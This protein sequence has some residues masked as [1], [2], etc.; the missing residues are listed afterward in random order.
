M[1]RLNFPE[2]SFRTRT[3][4]D[5]TEIYDPVRRKYVVLTPEEWVRQN[6]I[7]Y[8]IE[9]KRMPLSLMAIE[10]GFR[11]IKLPKRPD[12]VIFSP[13]GAPLLIVE[14]KAPGIA[15]S[16]D[17]FD[18]IVRYNMI[19]NALFLLVTN[20]MNHFI[21]EIDYRKTSYRFLKEIPSYTDIISQHIDKNK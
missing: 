21:C 5:K 16:Q 1:I 18:Q 4:K 8:L 15:V 9:E 11:L 6:T 3:T 14:C 10:A 20:G 19:L 12:I 7:R 2:Y 13:D 17:T